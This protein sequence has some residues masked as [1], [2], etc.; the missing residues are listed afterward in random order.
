M[1]AVGRGHRAGVRVGVARRRRCRRRSGTDRRGRC[2]ASC[3]SWPVRHAL[4]GLQSGSV[5]HSTGLAASASE[6]PSPGG[7]ARCRRR[8]RQSSTGRDRASM[9]R[10][11]ADAPP[12]ARSRPRARRAR[13]RSPPEHEATRGRREQRASPR[14]SS[15]RPCPCRSWARR[16]PA[17]AFGEEHERD[18]AGDEDA[19]RDPE[20]GRPRGEAVG[21]DEPP[22]RRRRVV[23]VARGLRREAEDD[24][25]DGRGDAD[26]DRGEADGALIGDGR[27]R[28]LD[29]RLRLGRR[30]RRGRSTFGATFARASRRASGTGPPRGS[31][32]RFSGFAPGRRTV[33]VCEPGRRVEADGQRHL[34]ELIELHLG[35]LGAGHDERAEPLLERGEALLRRPDLLLVQPLRVERA[36]VNASAARS[37]W[38][39]C[40]HASAA[41]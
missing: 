10:P 23:R 35:A 27:N 38:F 11:R 16:R 29:G 6:P 30:W 7:A 36:T 34:G 25:R 17:A 33:S 37:D 20:H 3:R 9:R 12:H 15:A 24:G 19:R 1:E 18:A 26:A 32:S 4:V 13:I 22:A 8:C 31:T 14:T 39:A 21:V 28:L 40:S 2:P 41:V 5:L